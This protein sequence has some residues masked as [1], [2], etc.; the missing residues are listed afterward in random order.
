MNV[1]YINSGERFKLLSRNSNP[2][3]TLDEKNRTFKPERYIFADQSVND[4][5][6]LYLYTQTELDILTLEYMINDYEKQG[7]LIDT[8]WM[9]KDLYPWFS[10]R[11]LIYTPR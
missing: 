2:T 9:E 10:S 3:A 8:E 11:L 7:K 4:A 6:S 5:V 1:D